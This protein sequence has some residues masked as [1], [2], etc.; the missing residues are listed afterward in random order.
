VQG[1]PRSPMPPG[2]PERRY[3]GMRTLASMC[4]VSAW[5]SLIF[6][7]I[8]GLSFLAVPVPSPG[9]ALPQRPDLDPGGLGGLGGGVGP[10]GGIGALLPML[11]GGLRWVGA[12]GTIGGGVLSFFFLAALGQGLYV[13][14]DMEENTRIT[15]Q[16]MAQIARRMGG[17]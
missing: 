5:L 15:A 11:A 9:I 12:L 3:G 17:G 4:I 1:A 10:A 2:Y 16:A 6:S 14:L 7:V 13:L 8:G